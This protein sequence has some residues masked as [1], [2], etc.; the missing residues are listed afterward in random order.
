M[1]ADLRKHFDR[2]VS[3]DPGADA[4]EMA[5]AA[6]AQGGRMRRRR[7]QMAGAGVAAGVVVALAVVGGVSLRPEPA[8]P[9]GPPMTVA[10]AM[11]PL[12]APSCSEKPVESGATDVVVFLIPDSTDRQSSALGSTLREDARVAD[13]RFENRQQA[14]ERFRTLWADSPDFVSSV[15][16]K[17]LVESFRLRLAD[18]AQY[19][20]FRAEYAT[21]D[22]VGSI[23]GR[24]CPASAPVGGVQ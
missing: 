17:Q 24:V 15:S 21:M 23:V 1:D 4:G 20:A 19:K 13:V 14:W 16:P 5:L 18:P 9:A 22:G 10:A 12:T 6:I 8:E 7:R 2:A 3:D 11:M